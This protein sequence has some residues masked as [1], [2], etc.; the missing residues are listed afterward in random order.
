MLV[1]EYLATGNDGHAAGEPE[2]A[3]EVVPQA[4]N[5]AVGV[6]LALVVFGAGCGGDRQ[7][8]WVLHYLL[9]RC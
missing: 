9:S 8:S 3:Y 6:F 2:P 7:P 4:C 1:I 5:L